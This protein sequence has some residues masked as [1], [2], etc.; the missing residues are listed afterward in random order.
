MGV[1]IVYIYMDSVNKLLHI[2]MEPISEYIADNSVQ[3][4]MVNHSGHIIIEHNNVLEQTKIVLNSDQIETIIRVVASDN[5]ICVSAEN[6]SFSS[7]IE[8]IRCRFQGLLPPASATPIFCIRKQCNYNNTLENLAQMGTLTPLQAAV[9][10]KYILEKKNILIAGATGSGKT[11]L[12]NAILQEIINIGDRIIVIE[13]TPELQIS[14][15][16]NV[17]LLVGENYN[18]TKAIFDVLRMR[19]D[20]IILG[21]LRNGAALD[22]LKA[23][24][25]G[26]GGGL[27][28]IHAN[29][30]E[31]AITRLVQLVEEVSLTPPKEFISEVLDLCV[32]ISRE[33]KKRC[34]K[35]MCNVVD[36]NAVENQFITKEVI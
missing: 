24:N 13:D 1:F 14:D 9:L 33:G 19:P 2:V 10:R 20:R 15:N 27:T 4:I 16:N 23:W 5:G 8:G 7:T 22:L 25:T 34:V 35:S 30:A 29:S 12:A 31:M 11:T 28:T 26:H 6:P 18:Y 21:E 3:E 32:F 17:R 36:F